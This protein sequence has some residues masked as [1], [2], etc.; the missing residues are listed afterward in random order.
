MKGTVTESFE[1]DEVKA[2][3]EVFRIVLRGGDARVV[4]RTRP[5]MRVL[6]KVAAMKAELGPEEAVG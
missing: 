1:A 4:A 6:Q 2:L 3:H 5:G